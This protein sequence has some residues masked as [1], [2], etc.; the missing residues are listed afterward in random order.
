MLDIFSFLLK[1]TSVG[2][3][4]FWSRE[5]KQWSEGQYPRFSSLHRLRSRPMSDLSPAALA[6]FPGFPSSAELIQGGPEPAG[7]KG[8]EKSARLGLPKL[9]CA[10][11]FPGELSPTLVPGLMNP[12]SLAVDAWI[13]SLKKNS[14]EDSNGRPAAL[15]GGS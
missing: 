6:S 5:R 1:R 9:Y 15:A 2:Q 14:S 13:V 11:G 3:A 8:S 12:G 10:H 7:S 4:P